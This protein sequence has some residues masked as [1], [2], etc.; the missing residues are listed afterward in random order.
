M[1]KD[2]HTHTEF[3]PHGTHEDTERFIIRAIEEGFDEY[4]ITE[5]APL[6]LEF[7]KRCSGIRRAID[8]AGIRLSDVGA[9]FKKM[10]RLKL[11]YQSEIKINIGF[12]VDY[13]PGFEN[14][15]TDF[16]NE[17]SDR[18]GDS[19]LSLHFLPGKGGWRSID[20]SSDDYQDGIVGFYGGFREAQ[21]VYLSYLQKSV[22]ADLGPYKPKRI[23]HI[24]LCQK[25]RKKFDK[26][27]TDFSSE[28]KNQILQILDAVQSGGYEL[29]FNTA[30]LYKP[31]CGEIYPA[32]DIVKLAKSIGIG[33]VYGSDA[34]SSNEVGRAYDQCPKNII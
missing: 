33:F 10:D 12:E 1:K 20:Y 6:P 5:H 27:D 21:S 13:L 15:T 24:T 31:Y 4:S 8:T 30:G 2:G 7:M 28:G 32:E 17:Y 18:I 26:E 29:D 25:F 16:L 23:G 19:I 34:H 3:C 9:Y 14:W 22:T 11:K